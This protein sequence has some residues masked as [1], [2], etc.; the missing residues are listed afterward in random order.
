MKNICLMEALHFIWRSHIAFYELNTMET[1]RKPFATG[2][3]SVV[4]LE[5][6]Q[7]VKKTHPNSKAI[8]RINNE[9]YWLN[10]VNKHNIGPKF[11]GATS[12]EIRLELVD[13]TRIIEWIRS[14]NRPAIKAVLIKIL[15]QCRTLDK[16]HVNKY[17]LTN[18]YK[19]IIIR[20]NEPIMIDF[21]RCRYAEKPKN[22]TQFCQFLMSKKISN[23][24]GEKEIILDHDDMQIS[25]RN[26]KKSQDAKRFAVILNFFKE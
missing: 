25:L 2:K 4:Y 16:I 3:R 18:P 14:S 21:E 12:S 9:I 10:L 5:G 26:Y 7:I 6:N 22:V 15:K 13:G 1:A 17:E 19:H 24:L 11:L 8:N 20:N 23:I